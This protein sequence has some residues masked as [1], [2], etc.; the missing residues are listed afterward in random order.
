[1]LVDARYD[2]AIKT[3]ALF[4][5]RSRNEVKH[6]ALWS[7]VPILE[8]APLAILSKLPSR[9]PCQIMSADTLIDD[10]QEYHMISSCNPHDCGRG[11]RSV[12]GSSVVNSGSSECRQYPT[13]K[14]S[15]LFDAL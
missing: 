10:R 5:G 8:M 1:M 4:T 2:N 15:D 13:Q 11:H 6:G 12:N 14:F 9:L 7:V 3:E